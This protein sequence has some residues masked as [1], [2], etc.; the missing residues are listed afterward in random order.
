MK[1]TG[2]AFSARLKMRGKS[3]KVTEAQLETP[4]QIY[5]KK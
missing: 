2:P 1:A 5:G 3:F 4:E